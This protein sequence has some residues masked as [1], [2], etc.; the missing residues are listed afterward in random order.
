M[1]CHPHPPHPAATYGQGGA[2]PAFGGLE[3]RHDGRLRVVH[4][5][6]VDLCVDELARE[7]TVDE[8]DPAIVVAG[9]RGPA[10]C[11]GRRS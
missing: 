2:T 8:H 5:L 4:V 7:G 10:G 11:H 3:H 6:V 1:C 9:E